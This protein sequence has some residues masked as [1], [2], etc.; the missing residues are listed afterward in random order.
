METKINPI[1]APLQALS[2]RLLSAAKDTSNPDIESLT[3]FLEAQALIQQ[4]SIIDQ[5]TQLAAESTD[6]LACSNLLLRAISTA[7]RTRN[8]LSRLIGAAPT[9]VPATERE[10]ACN[11]LES[12]LAGTERPAKDLIAAARAL[13]ITTRTLY[14]AKSDLN[15]ISIQKASPEGA[16]LART[17]FWSLPTP[18][19]TVQ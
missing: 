4:Q 19:L 9:P 6:R 15:I 18:T 3:P 2:E 17:W 11:F 12:E 7:D 14:R 1:I 5:L 8:R 13:G 16:A 10:E